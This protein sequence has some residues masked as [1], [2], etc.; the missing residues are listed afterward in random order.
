[1]LKKTLR[2]RLPSLKSYFPFI[3]CFLLSDA[4]YCHRIFVISCIETIKRQFSALINLHTD[5]KPLN[6][7]K[8]AMKFKKKAL[9]TAK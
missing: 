8:N 2:S 9:K 4:F 7:L 1:M 5:F 6:Q 3:M